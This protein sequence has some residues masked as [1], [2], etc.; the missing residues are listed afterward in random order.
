MQSIERLTLRVNAKCPGIGLRASWLVLAAAVGFGWGFG[1]TEVPLGNPYDPQTPAAQQQK[2]GVSG[3]A[4]LP[5]GFEADRFESGIAVARRRR[6][7]HRPASGRPRRPKWWH[8]GRGG[9]DPGVDRVDE[10]GAVP[11]RA[12]HVHRPAGASVRSD[13]AQRLRSP[14]RREPR[15]RDIG[16]RHRGGYT[17]SDGRLR[18]RLRSAAMPVEAPVDESATPHRLGRGPGFRSDR[19]ETAGG[20]DGDGFNTIFLPSQQSWTQHLHREA[21]TPRSRGASTRATPSS[22]T[23]TDTTANRVTTSSP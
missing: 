16:P 21:T 11:H 6:G 8:S 2:A 14:L 17:H 15:H 1:C 18:G 22:S 20:P 5:A 10:R 23:S 19:R 12:G 4:L 3:F 13:S 7:G 9:A